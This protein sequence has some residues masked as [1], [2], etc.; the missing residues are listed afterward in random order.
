MKA[1]YSIALATIIG[2]FWFQS[3]AAENNESLDNAAVIEL[4]KLGLGDA[5]IVD[6]IKTTRGHFDVSVEGLKQLKSAGVSAEVMRAMIGT[7]SSGQV[8]G[9]QTATVDVNDPTSP[10]DAGIWL[11][12]EKEG[13]AK[14]T[15]L[16]PSA[17][18]QTKHGVAIFAQYG[19][20][21]KSEA[22]LRSAHATL[23]T[24][25]RRPV[26]YF[27]FEVSKAGLSSASGAVTSPNEFVLAEFK[28]DEKN[29]LRKLVVGQF[30]AYT[31]GQIGPED[32]SVRSFGFDK[33]TPG[34][35]KVQLKTDLASGEY[36]F[37]Y[38]GPAAGYGGKIL[39]FGVVGSP[40]TEPK[41][42]SGK[43]PKPSKA[44]K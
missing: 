41:K 42:A 5:V 14:M 3:S 27:Y 17:Y 36:G 9:G 34:I 28:K 35:Y 15:L 39:D 20:T 43:E 6:K 19:Q 32:K 33:I 12:E 4:Q 25:N 31:G 10:H 29:N 38:A 8:S 40:D 23:Q 1:Y 21:A 24:S 2:C 30:N 11:Y 22:V 16:E 37:F 18:S 26:F 7:T 13:K 44:A